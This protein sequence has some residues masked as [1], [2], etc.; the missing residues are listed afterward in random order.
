[1]PVAPHPSPI[2]DAVPHPAR[3][4]R[5]EARP[6]E[7][8]ASAL[9]LFAEK[10]F[11]ATR[12]EEVAALAGVSK[13]T[14]YLYY[15][16]KEELLKAVIRDNLGQL[17]AEGQELVGSFEGST[18]ELLVCLMQ[19]W[20]ERVGNTPAAALHKIIVAEARNFPEI[21]EFYTNEVIAPADRLMSS[22]VQRGIDRGEFR[23]VPVREVA[24]CLLAP[25]I[26]L[27]LHQ[28]SI[29]VTC[30][31]GFGDGDPRSVVATHIDVML[32]GLMQRSDNLDALP[33]TPACP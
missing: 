13:G 27:S 6:Q 15:P 18:A 10:G 32:R 7:L 28:H 4:R 29:G 22:A 2:G 30:P 5:K 16:S 20:W 12:T 25:V 19:T 23:P 33:P 8:L 31:F 14:L 11:A 24:I 26:F 17:I 9:T 3:Q 1:M 21:S